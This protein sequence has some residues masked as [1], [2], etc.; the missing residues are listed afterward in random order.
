M[1]GISVHHCVFECVSYSI[2][3]HARYIVGIHH[4]DTVGLDVTTVSLVYVKVKFITIIQLIDILL[5]TN[6]VSNYHLVM[7]ANQVRINW[8]WSII[9]CFKGWNSLRNASKNIVSKLAMLD[10]AACKICSYQRFKFSPRSDRITGN[11][12]KIF[13]LSRL[14]NY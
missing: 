3:N 2:V 9:Q 1:T 14:S 10:V 6:Y 5:I 13:I 12:H 4:N 11:D 8:W 7:I